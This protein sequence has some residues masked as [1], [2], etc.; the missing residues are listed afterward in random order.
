MS[1]LVAQDN[2]TVKEI[3]IDVMVTWC[4]TYNKHGTG[5]CGNTGNV[6]IKRLKIGK[7]LLHWDKEISPP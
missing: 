3:D 1:V 2:T 7:N 5:Y 6:G 4:G